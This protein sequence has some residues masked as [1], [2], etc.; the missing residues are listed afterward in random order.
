MTQ[1]TNDEFFAELKRAKH[2]LFRLELQKAYDEPGEAEQVRQFLA[3]QPINPCDTELAGWFEQVQLWN[4]MGI[5]ITRVRVHEDAPT[6]YQQWVRWLGQWNEDAGECMFYLTRSK[7]T[8]IGLLP[9]V[10]DVDWWLIDESRLLEL[11]FD[12]NY[13]RMA[14]RLITNKHVVDAACTWR[15]LALR[16]S[17]RDNHRAHTA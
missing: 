16:H 2:S 8:K 14:N 9:E 10:G 11:S 6:A 1:L 17:T 3:G 4:S 7:A 13:Q 5:P 15:D 12:Q